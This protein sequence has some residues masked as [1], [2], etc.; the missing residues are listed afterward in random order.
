MSIDFFTIEF[1]ISKLET[2]KRL[3]EVIEDIKPDDINVLL[4]IAEN[5]NR[6]DILNET[7]L[8][9]NLARNNAIENLKITYLSALLQQNWLIIK[10]LSEISE[11]INICDINP[12]TSL[13][14]TRDKKDLNSTR[15]S[16]AP[17]DRR[18]KNTINYYGKDIK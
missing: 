16:K 14:N 4:S 6:V 2:V 15:N 10:K 12:E 1:K 13:S 8:M 9:Q 3:E 11:K 18:K 5:V 7:S 17:T